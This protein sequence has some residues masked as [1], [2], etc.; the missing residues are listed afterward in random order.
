MS[1]S[2]AKKSRGRQRIEIKKMSNDINLQVT[3]SKRRSGLFKK[4]SELCTLCGASV[5]LVVFSPGEKVFSFGHPSVDGVIERYLKRGPPPEAGNMHYMAKVIELNGQLT[6]INDQLEAERKH[7][8]KLNRKQKEAEAQ[9]WWAR[10]VEGMIIME[11]LEK[12][13]KAFE[14]LK[15]QVAGLADMALSQSVANGNP[16]H[17]FFPGASSSAIPNVVLQP[18]SLPVVQVLPP[19]THMMLPPPPMMFQNYTLPDH[20]SMI[21][22]P[23][24]FNNDMGMG[25]GGAFGVPGPSSA[26]AGGGFF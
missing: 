6:H 17:Q 13:K 22:N 4:A 23:N 20:G 24:G 5:A 18:T 11:N 8:E 10:P 14:E 19:V 21:M 12:L 9:L 16:G 1:S 15:Q 2:E 26:G 7:A 3:F 25:G